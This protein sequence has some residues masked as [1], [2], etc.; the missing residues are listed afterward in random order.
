MKIERTLATVKNLIRFMP[1]GV[2]VLSV[3]LTVEING[4]D[5]SVVADNDSGFGCLQI[6]DQVWIDG[7]HNRYLFQ[8]QKPIRF[9]TAAWAD[10]SPAQAVSSVGCCDMIEGSKIL[11][12][13]Y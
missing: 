8:T 7:Q 12:P 9:D 6:G 11:I 1:P 10:E 2:R 3:A 5:F 4:M 13:N